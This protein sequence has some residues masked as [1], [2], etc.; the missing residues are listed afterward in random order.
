MLAT[1]ASRIISVAGPPPPSRSVPSLRSRSRSAV[2]ARQSCASGM[3]TPGIPSATMAHLD[4]TLILALVSLARVGPGALRHR[5]KIDTRLLWFAAF[6][7]TAPVS[8]STSAAPDSWDFLSDCA[9]CC[10]EWAIRRRRCAGF[11]VTLASRW[12]VASHRRI[13]ALPAVAAHERRTARNSR[14]TRRQRLREQYRGPGGGH[15]VAGRM[16]RE[17]PHAG[18]RRRCEYAPVPRGSRHR[19]PGAQTR[20]LLVPPFPQ[21]V[22]ADG[23]RTRSRSACCLSAWIFWVLVRGPYRSRELGAAACGDRRG[24][25]GGIPRRAVFPQTDSSGGIRPRGGD[26][27]RGAAERDCDESRRRRG[28]AG[29]GPICLR[30]SLCSR[31]V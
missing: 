9:C 10:C 12:R 20:D 26:A 5:T 4:Y 31:A 3:P 14:R 2:L 11:A 22:R 6:A 24:L 21:P 25:S 16:V 30:L 28:P 17:D 27:S 19:P 23:D 8:S 29:F 7:V 13:L 1:V 18:H 15:R